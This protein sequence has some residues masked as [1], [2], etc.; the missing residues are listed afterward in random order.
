MA[1]TEHWWQDYQVD[2]PESAIGDWA[3]ERFEVSKRE[4]E[5]ESLRAMASTLNA[6]RGVPEGR[7]TRL[8]RGNTVVMSDT[9]DKIR[10]HLRAI[11]RATGDC[12]VNGLGLGVVVQAMLRREVVTTVTV[13]EKCQEVH[14]MVGGYYHGR[15]GR[16][17]V[18]IH[19][20][21]FTW[22]PPRGFRYHVVWH[23]IW[24]NMCLDNL[25]E[26]TRLHRRYGRRCEWQGAWGRDA[27]RLRMKLLRRYESR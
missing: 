22:Q 7:Y 1:I 8:M 11:R 6:G 16:R 2:I 20:D 21:A 5:M 19:D 18:L 25:A 4:A 3:V 26:M 9:P 17:L 23:D 10:D 15:F 24:D 13:V 27:L 12:L 14:D